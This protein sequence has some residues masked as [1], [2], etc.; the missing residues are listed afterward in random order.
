MK[1]IQL[2]NIC[3]PSSDDDDGPLIGSHGIT[4]LF[5]DLSDNDRLKLK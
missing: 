3:F 5:E 4:N 1:L 2:S